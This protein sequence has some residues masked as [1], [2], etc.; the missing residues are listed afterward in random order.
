MT[1]IEKNVMASVRVIYGVRQLMNA[2]ALKVYVFTLSI[3][4]IATLVSL[5]HVVAN[6]LNVAHGGLPSMSVF[7]AA[8]LIQ[9]K[10]LVQIA[11][12]LGVL[13]FVLLTRDMLRSISQHHSAPALG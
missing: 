8:A 13:S 2:T 7:I 12:A 4:G 3:L 6:F 11:L 1:T 9:T 10:V 5:P